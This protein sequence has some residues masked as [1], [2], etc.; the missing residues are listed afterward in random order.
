MC[1]PTSKRSRSPQAEGTAG[2]IASE[3]DQVA[4]WG[5]LSVTEAI[6]LS[7][8]SPNVDYVH[9]MLFLG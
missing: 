3:E 6:K 1:L 2:K 7:V 8:A 5:Q 4:S 9:G